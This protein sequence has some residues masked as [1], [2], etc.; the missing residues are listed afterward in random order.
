MWWNMLNW[1]LG[2][3]IS[4]HYFNLKGDRMKLRMLLLWNFSSGLKFL[5][6]HCK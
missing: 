4:S 5:N 1:Y 2:H 3:Y 6:V